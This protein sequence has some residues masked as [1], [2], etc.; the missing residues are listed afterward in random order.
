MCSSSLSE[1]LRSIQI[2]V[3]L[4]APVEV[5]VPGHSDCVP[6][7]LAVVLVDLSL[8]GEGS[9]ELLNKSSVVVARCTL[10]S[11]GSGAS[12]A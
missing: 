4:A 12:R 1:E 11:L 7:I 3:L 8:V 5:S 10:I 2:S 6:V 9:S